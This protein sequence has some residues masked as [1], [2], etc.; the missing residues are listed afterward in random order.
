MVILLL[1]STML[2]VESWFIPIMALTILPFLMVFIISL[3]ELLCLKN[4]WKR[5]IMVFTINIY[6]YIF[7]VM[8][9]AACT[10]P[11]GSASKEHKT[12]TMTEHYQANGTNRPSSQPDPASAAPA[13]T[14]TTSSACH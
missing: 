4:R 9:I 13:G 12:H 6:L 14:A 2:A 8:A 1:G 10:T 3:F 11:M 7:Y 5:I